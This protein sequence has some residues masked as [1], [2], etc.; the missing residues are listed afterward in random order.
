MRRTT[1]AAA[2]LLA[3]GLA[4]GAAAA[5]IDPVATLSPVTGT[6]EVRHAETWERG[7]DGT[8]LMRKDHVRTGRASSARIVFHDAVE[9]A[10]ATTVDVVPGTEVSLEQLEIQ[11]GRPPR[12]VGFLGLLRGAVRTW[13]KGWTGGSIFSTK[14]GTTVCGI[15]GS[16]V[17]LGRD[18]A[19][20]T[21][22]MLGGDVIQFHFA[23]PAKAMEIARRLGAAPASV[24]LAPGASASVYGIPLRRLEVGYVAVVTET[25]DGRTLVREV[26]LD[27]VQLA[28]VRAAL[29]KVAA[30]AGDVSALEAAMAALGEAVGRAQEVARA[31]PAREAAGRTWRRPKPTPEDDGTGTGTGSGSGSGDGSGDGALEE[32]RRLRR[33]L[34]GLD[35]GLD[36]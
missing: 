24:G 23:D 14:T 25:E 30:A 33:S 34:E 1:I 13:T 27:P 28:A 12:R 19:E 8:E 11:P 21:V 2:G 22:M 18:G 36:R 31:Q 32:L 20:S 6:V 15:R 5:E 7:L 17:F 10:A 26:V 9:G 3:L 35:R 29:A 16:E 4:A